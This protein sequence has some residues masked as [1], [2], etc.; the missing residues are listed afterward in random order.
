MKSIQDIRVRRQAL[1]DRAG[2]LINTHRGDSWTPAIARQVDDLHDEIGECDREIRTIERTLERDR[3][4]NTSTTRWV[5]SNGNELPVAF[6]KDGPLGSQLR[7]AGAFKGSTASNISLSDC[8]RGIAGMKTTSADI[9]NTLSE[10]TDSAGG[11][12]LPQYVQQQMLDALAPVSSLLQAGAGVTMLDAGGGGGAKSWRI[13]AMSSIPTA[14]WRSESG[15]VATSDP[16]FRNV[17]L[18]PRS[19]AFMFKISRELLADSVNL[20]PSLYRVIAQAF[21]KELDRVGLRGSGTPPEPRGIL[22]TSGIQAV[23]NGAN[24]NSIATTAYAN[25]VAAVQAILQTD[26]PMPTAAIMAPRSLTTIGG[27]LDT[28]NQPRRVPPMLEPMKILATSQI[29]ITLTVGT[30]SDCSEIYVADFSNHFFFLRE[31]VSIQRLNE[32][33]AATGELAFVCHVRADVGVLYPS[34]FAVVTGVRA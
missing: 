31:G 16:V 20:E 28:T 17:D 10:G 19:L 14:A 32:L 25:L 3:A 12:T 34:A 24:G 23:S 26:G 13:A 27:L 6:A 15:N 1:A 30:S 9:R 21:A 7:N 18:T 22:N 29:P 11:Y 2:Q 33:Y 8:L 5:D 4:G